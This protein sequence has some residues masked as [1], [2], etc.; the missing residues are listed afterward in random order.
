MKMLLADMVINAIDSALQDSEKAFHGVCC[1]ADAVFISHV[2]VRVMVHLIVLAAHQ[3]SFERGRAV[4]HDVGVFRYHRL[5]NRLQILSGDT[6]D[7]HRLDTAAALQDSHNGSFVR[8]LVANVRFFAFNRAG[9]LRALPPI[10]V[11]SIS[12]MPSSFDDNG[13][14]V[15][16]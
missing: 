8:G 6:R 5:N 9:A 2:F 1:D 3:G 10:H 11:S 13:S 15:I 12:I 7:M 14:W 16:V 4:R